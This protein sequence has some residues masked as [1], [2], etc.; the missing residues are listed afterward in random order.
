MAE[1]DVGRKIIA[2]SNGTERATYFLR[3]ILGY[4]GNGAYT[5]TLA[6]RAVA[7]GETVSVLL[8]S[9]APEFPVPALFRACVMKFE[10]D[11]Q[12]PPGFQNVVTYSIKW[13]CADFTARNI[14]QLPNGTTAFEI[15]GVGIIGR[16]RLGEGRGGDVEAA[17]AAAAAAMAAGMPFAEVLNA[18]N[19]SDERIDACSGRTEDEEC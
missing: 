17:L 4:G 12:K 7:K 19:G 5:V 6:Q 13:D 10:P 16:A 18:L 1:M 2:V 15:V 8:T 14:R 9:D 3:K 11:R